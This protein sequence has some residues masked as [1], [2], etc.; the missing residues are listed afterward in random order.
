MNTTGRHNGLK[1][2][3]DIPA[4]KGNQES[5]EDKIAI[6]KGVARAN[7][8]RFNEEDVFKDPQ[9][10]ADK[11]TKV[12]A[13]SSELMVITKT[14]KLTAYVITI[15]EKSPKHFRAVFVNRMQNYCLDCLELLIEANSL[16]MDNSKNKEKRKNCQ[17]EAYLKLK[18]LGYIAFLALENKCIIKKQYQQISLQTADCINL[19]TAWRRSDAERYGTNMD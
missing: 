1:L 11:E 10:D 2:Q 5:D 12:R 3:K 13:N 7:G 18:L 4:V 6:A 14:K 19:L 17:H 16:R 9:T 15:T 8:E